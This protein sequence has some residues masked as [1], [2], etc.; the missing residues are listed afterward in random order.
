MNHVCEE[1]WFEDV[2]EKGADCPGCMY[3]MGQM[4]MV[5]Y[6]DRAE[7]LATAWKSLLAVEDNCTAP[8][9]AR[10]RTL[11]AHIEET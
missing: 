1:S 3:E 5:F 2:K 6:K 11:L 4:S 9:L 8:R 7:S 10:A